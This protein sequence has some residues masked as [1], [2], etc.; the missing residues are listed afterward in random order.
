MLQWVQ[1]YLRAVL[2]LCYAKVFRGSISYA[3]LS[4]WGMKQHFGAFLPFFALPRWVINVSAD[5]V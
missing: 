5:G 3:K 2:L 4:Y 1:M